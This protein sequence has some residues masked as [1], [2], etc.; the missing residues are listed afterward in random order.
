MAA[1]EDP[2]SDPGLGELEALEADEA[3]NDGVA[4]SRGV[5]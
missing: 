4:L 1:A 5:G 3:D 2:L